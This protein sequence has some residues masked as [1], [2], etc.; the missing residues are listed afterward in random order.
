MNR[1]P[2]GRWTPNA[3]ERSNRRPPTKSLAVVGAVVLTALV[4][5]PIVT[6]DNVLTGLIN[7]V[8]EA[9]YQGSDSTSDGKGDCDALALACAAAA[10]GAITGCV[11][12]TVSASG[13]Y[14]GSVANL[15]PFDGAVSVSGTATS[16][17]YFTSA[18]VL[19]GVQFIP[20]R[21]DA[22]ARAGN[23]DGCLDE[24]GTRFICGWGAFSTSYHSPPAWC[25]LPPLGHQSCGPAGATRFGSGLACVGAEAWVDTN[26]GSQTT[27]VQQQVQLSA[28]GLPP[29]HQQGSATAYVFARSD[30]CGAPG[31][32]HPA[33]TIP[34]PEGSEATE[35][36]VDA[37]TV[38]V[39][40][41]CIASQEGTS[42]VVVAWDN[43]HPAV[44]AK[45][46]S[47]LR[48]QMEGKLAADFETRRPT[49][50]TGSDD[51]VA[52]L[53]AVI[54][55]QARAAADSYAGPVRFERST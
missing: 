54:L 46:R 18:L 22:T 27:L 3:T 17:A 25:V 53:E 30:D 36:V 8:N 15:I 28:T 39:C 48:H 44:Q 52:R 10:A 23:L 5:T 12:T 31:H 21:V 51:A 41:N 33:R 43:V 11:T 42:D 2:S 26:G 49:A 38:L 16:C 6:A 14:P 50:M 7:V 32:H 55:E 1:T 40:S 4:A 19:G 34:P 9:A 24:D 29:L 20:G 35:Q 13:S 45:I 47:G 37:L